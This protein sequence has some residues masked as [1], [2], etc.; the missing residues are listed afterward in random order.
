MRAV[1]KEESYWQVVVSHWGRQDR[2]D[3]RE[4]AEAGEP[5]KV[6]N[7]KGTRKQGTRK[8]GSRERLGNRGTGK[9]G[10]AGEGRRK[11]QDDRGP[12][13]KVENRR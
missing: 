8:Q 2:R 5:G 13:E 10:G 4:G 1:E 7:R 3:V 12:P 11:G 9:A 6:E